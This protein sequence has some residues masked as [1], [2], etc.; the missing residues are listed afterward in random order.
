MW[1]ILVVN[2]E[3]HGVIFWDLKKIAKENEQ[4]LLKDSERI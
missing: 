2:T 4:L 3:N 1:D